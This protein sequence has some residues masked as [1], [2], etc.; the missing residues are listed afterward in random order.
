MHE[1]QGPA[2]ELGDV[3]PGEQ[4][5]ALFERAR[6]LLADR[7]RPIGEIA[8]ELGC[9]HPT[10][11]RRFRAWSGMTPSEWRDQHAPS[12]ASRAEHADLMMVS[13]KLLQAILASAASVAG[14]GASPTGLRNPIEVPANIGDDGVA[15]LRILWEVLAAQVPGA[16]AGV[17]MAERFCNDGLE[18]VWRYVSAS[19]NHR[20]AIDGI[21]R[22]L[23]LIASDLEVAVVE[24]ERLAEVEMRTPWPAHPLAAEFAIAL[25]VRN[26][27]LLQP[28]DAD[29]VAITFAHPALPD[30]ESVHAGFFRCPVRFGTGRNTVV[31]S[32][33]RFEAPHA[34]VDGD[35]RAL[36]EDEGTRRIA[37][38]SVQHSE[39]VIRREY[40]RAVGASDVRISEIAR[41]LGASSRTLQRDLQAAGLSHRALVDDARHEAARTLMMHGLSVKEVAAQLGFAN[42]TSFVRSFKRWTGMTP[43]DYRS[44]LVSYPARLP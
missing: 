5:A 16:G 2:G 22:F 39:Q 33:Q 42:T 41:R 43:G 40:R 9:D 25:L 3:T 10:F 1:V 36:V 17:R 4:T 12:E 24:D 30:S 32:R 28:E 27:R 14:E 44:Q 19:A 38:H 20:E 29:P 11:C 15:R 35:L 13:A 21:S 6:N 26:S 18:I 34:H 37:K 8:E 23:P 7:E 31:W